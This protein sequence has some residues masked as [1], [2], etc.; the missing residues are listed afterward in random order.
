[1]A[2]G[3]ITGD[4]PEI[5]ATAAYSRFDKPEISGRN[6]FHR[7]RFFADA[8][9][10]SRTGGCTCGSLSARHFEYSISAGNTSSRMNAHM[11]A[12]TSSALADGAKS[13]CSALLFESDEAL[14]GD[15]QDL[16]V[17]VAE[18]LPGH[19]AD[20]HPRGDALCDHRALEMCERL[21]ESDVVK[22][23]AGQLCV[24]FCEMGP[25]RE[26]WVPRHSRSQYPL[27][28]ARLAPVEEK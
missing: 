10:C 11:R 28:L 3:A 19:C 23:R 6:R 24:A 25:C 8:F 2:S 13:I 27:V 26:A 17:E 21:I 7:S 22:L 9:K 18:V 15:L 20:R 14:F 12:D 16:F 4:H 5:S 1:M